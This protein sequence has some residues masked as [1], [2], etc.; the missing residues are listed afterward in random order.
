MSAFLKFSQSR[1]TEVKKEN[2]D[3]SN[4]DVSRLLGEMWRNAPP[5]EKAPYVDKEEIERAQYKIDIAKFKAGQARL[6][7]ASRTNH[8]LMKPAAPTYLNNAQE[9]DT[10]GDEGIFN[11]Q[12]QPRDENL[13][14]PMQFHHHPSQMMYPTFMN[15]YSFNAESFDSSEI[16]PEIYL[17]PRHPNYSLHQHSTGSENRLPTPP[18]ETRAHR[19]YDDNLYHH[20]NRGYYNGRY[21]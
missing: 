2:P 10:S 11:L 1:R 7:A 12:A 19:E 15:S 4:T 9:Q 16:L 5:K 21:H 8:N 18:P 14:D 6:D 3:M 13:T 20:Y 17:P